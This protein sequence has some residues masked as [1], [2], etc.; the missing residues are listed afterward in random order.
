VYDEVDTLVLREKLAKKGD[1]VVIVA[2]LPFGKVGGTN[3]IMV[4]VVGDT[5][6][7]TGTRKEKAKKKK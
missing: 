6:E 1:R 2:G 7:K 3:M 4:H 5:T